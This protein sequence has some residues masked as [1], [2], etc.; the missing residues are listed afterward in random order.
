MLINLFEFNKY[1]I[2]NFFYESIKQ[3]NEFEFDEYNKRLI[4]LLF[5][6]S[7]LK[8]CDNDIIQEIKEKIPTYFSK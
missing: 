5:N 1:E 4:C 2:F 6:E 8:N 7:N 3:L